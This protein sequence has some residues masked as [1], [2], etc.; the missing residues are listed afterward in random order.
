MGLPKEQPR[1][2]QHPNW[3]PIANNVFDNL[4]LQGSYSAAI[5]L[6]L[7][8]KCYWAKANAVT[9]TASQLVKVFKLDAHTADR[10]LTELKLAGLIRQTQSGVKRSKTQKPV[11][12]VPAVSSFDPA[13]GWTP[14]PRFLIRKYPRLYPDAVVLPYL[15]FCQQL[16]RRD[17]SYPS[18]RKIGSRFNW[19]TRTVS[20]VIRDLTNPENW[21]KYRVPC[22]L[23][24]KIMRKDGKTVRHLSVTAISYAGR[25]PRITRS[26]RSAFN[27]L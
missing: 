8:D 9:V 20:R 21:E 12:R 15:I 25:Y 16:S 5:Y 11:Y 22:P 18:N 23:K 27:C 14:I 26:F 17:F 1:Y 2:L 10:C 7:Y 4:S 13:E 3:T 24:S 19:S 6:W